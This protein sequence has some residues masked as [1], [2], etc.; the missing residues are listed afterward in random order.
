MPTWQASAAR[1]SRIASAAPEASPRRMSSW[2]NGPELE[3][4]EQAGVA[5]LGREVRGL[6]VVE[7]IGRER[8]QERGGSA[9]DEAVEQHGNAVC[10]RRQQGAGHRGDLA[11]A[12]PAQ[13]L[14]RIAER[15]GVAG[16]R[17]PD[18]GRLVR[19]AVP[20]Q[21]G[22]RPGPPRRRAAEQR[23]PDRRRGG[24]V[25]DAHLAERQQIQIGRQRSHAAIERVQALR[26]AHR[27]L[28]AEIAGR[29][30]ELERHDRE[31]P[32]RRPGTA[33]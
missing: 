14:E 8:V 26:L 6:G 3:A 20:V 15:L 17:A 31:L 13:H 11:A 5:G 30:L 25:A 32:R 19:H 27:R 24:G 22:A 16:Q 9:G 33:D 10:A 21:A 23:R 2:S 18:H 29:A 1:H 12:D 28:D 4:L 7:R